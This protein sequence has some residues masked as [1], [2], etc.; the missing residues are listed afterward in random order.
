MS[1]DEMTAHDLRSAL[2]SLGLNGFRAMHVLGLDSS[3]PAVVFGRWVAGE[4]EIPPAVARLIHAYLNDGYRPT[5]WQFVPADTAD[6]LASLHNLRLNYTLQYGALWDIRKGFGFDRGQMGYILGY[7]GM[8]ANDQISR[9]ELGEREM[10][11]MQLRL[12]IA[13]LEGYRPPDWGERGIDSTDGAEFSVA[14]FDAED[15]NLP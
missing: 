2:K 10:R 9:I 12:L 13:Y 7:I 8:N 3:K 5:D 11:A 6:L 15:E 4:R 14:K 1:I